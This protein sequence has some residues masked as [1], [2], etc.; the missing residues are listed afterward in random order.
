M[1]GDIPGYHAFFL[2]FLD[3][4]LVAAALVNTE[5]GDVI[6]PSIA[7]LQ[8]LAEPQSG[9]QSPT[10]QANNVYQDP[11]GRFS[12]TLV[13]NWTPVETDG[14]YIQVANADTPLILS[15]VTV[16]SDDFE[17]GVDAALRQVGLDPAA[18][19][20]TNRSSW[21]KW[22]VLSYTMGP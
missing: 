2:G 10:A 19:T 15:L 4:N 6:M 12:I 21:D 5:E 7:A 14:T 8:Y 18:L 13:G 16:E 11:E 20:E 17:A 3:T 9:E 22:D 1:G